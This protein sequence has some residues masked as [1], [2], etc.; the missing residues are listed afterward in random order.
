MSNSQIQ[1]ANY[2]LV[3]VITVV[4]NAKELLEGTILSV[5]EQ[6]Y[7]NIEY[8]II[9][10]GS[11]DGT[12]EIIQKYQDRIS[13]YIS[14][15][16]CGIYDAMN[17]GIAL[18]KGQW[19]NF[20]NA[21]DSFYSKD[22]LQKVFAHEFSQDI[23]VIYGNTDI[24]HKILKYK[25]ELNLTDMAQGMMLCHQSSFYRLDSSIKYNLE[26]KICAD[27]DF[28]MQYFKQGKSSRYL[29]ITISKYDLDGISSQ[30]LNKI[31]KEKLRIN[32]SYRLSYIPVIKSYVISLL[33]KL[34]RYFRGY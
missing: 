12:L 34:R 27:Q 4:Y 8:I 20:M 32:K 23:A 18:A 22:V 29:D 24:G 3:T 13:S 16:D 5:L 33:V 26:Y 1:K 21:G 7:P 31:L 14:E 6:A 15:P 17:K 10:G 9:D 2:P 30:N 28:T 11:T 19:L 25:S